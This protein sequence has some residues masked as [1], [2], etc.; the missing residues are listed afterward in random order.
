LYEHETYYLFHKVFILT[1]KEKLVSPSEIR[2]AEDDKKIIYPEFLNINFAHPTLLEINKLHEWLEKIGAKKITDGIILD[3]IIRFF[4]QNQQLIAQNQDIA[5]IVSI[6]IVSCL[7]QLDLKESEL[8]K[9]QQSISQLYLLTS[10]MQLRQANTCYLPSKFQPEIDLQS[11]AINEDIFV[12]TEY[13]KPVSNIHKVRSIL[14]ALGVGSNIVLKKIAIDSMTNLLA[15]NYCDQYFDHLKTKDKVD[16]FAGYHFQQDVYFNHISLLSYPSYAKVFWE[17]VIEDQK[18]IVDSIKKFSITVKSKRRSITWP[19]TPYL[20][21]VLSTFPCVLC[22]DDKLYKITEV[23]SPV[24]VKQLGKRLSKKILHIR[25]DDG[26]KIKNLSQELS[27]LLKFKQ[28]LSSNDCLALL[29]FTANNYNQ[30]TYEDFLRIYKV[31]CNHDETIMDSYEVLRRGETLLLA[32]DNTLQPSGELYFLP[33]EVFFEPLFSK[34]L[35]K[36]FSELSQNELQK[37][38]KIFA[39]NP[40]EIDDLIVHFS[41]TEESYS[42]EDEIQELLKFGAILE[43]SKMQQSGKKLFQKWKKKLTCIKLITTENL[44]IKFKKAEH[45]VFTPRIFFNGKDFYYQNNICFKQ[46]IVK[47]IC[48]VMGMT[49]PMSQELA[50][51]A[52]YPALARR[53]ILKERGYN[54]HLL[55]NLNS[56]SFLLKNDTEI[57]EIALPANESQLNID[58]PQNV[59]SDRDISSI[60]ITETTDIELGSRAA[61]SIKEIS[62][63]SIMLVTQK[64]FSEA[65]TFRV[66]SMKETKTEGMRK[67]DIYS[68]VRCLEPEIDLHKEEKIRQSSSINSY[69]SG[70]QGEEIVYCKLK[71]HYL[72]KYPQCVFNETEKGFTLI[73]KNE[74]NNTF[75]L[76]VKWYNKVKESGNSADFEIIKNGVSRFVEVKST[77]QLSH[78]ILRITKN[79]WN[80]M[81]MQ[82]E[83][84]RFFCVY[85]VDKQFNNIKIIKLKDPW[86][87]L[88]TGALSPQETVIKLKAL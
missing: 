3:D 28:T 4:K 76:E 70:R 82:G 27:V 81:R 66:V 14:I 12:S 15:M 35:L 84:Y 63:E 30:N 55:E 59:K 83:Y 33:K 56:N 9:I 72:K 6:D 36:P 19:A 65:C 51:L 77:Y 62:P 69:W 29:E 74:E 22:N 10:N 18:T 23:Y 45:L 54:V 87:H 2:I 73:G 53:D 1:H 7:A 79:E 37:I 85:G 49:E 64:F 21:F 43:S 40:M 67:E 20:V 75:S 71:F 80:L 42:V 88:M 44:T 16:F 86:K 11:D 41:L 5:K 48:K 13:I 47:A 32:A 39:I 38:Y 34:I 50:L 8:D 31:F 58:S 68:Q 24:L 25:T 17:K 78:M 26:K 46:D 60:D 57:V 52:T 61:R